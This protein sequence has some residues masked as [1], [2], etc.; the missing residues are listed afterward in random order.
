MGKFEPTLT[1][2][3]YCGKFKPEWMANIVSITKKNEK[4]QAYTFEDVDMRSIYFLGWYTHN[5]RWK[6]ARR[7][8]ELSWEKEDKSGM[9]RE[10]FCYLQ[11]AQFTYFFFY[12][13]LS[14]IYI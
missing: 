4:I 13:L 1:L 7:Q 3:T 2:G 8:P 6:S 10:I 12:H 14:I 5:G 11:R 9:S